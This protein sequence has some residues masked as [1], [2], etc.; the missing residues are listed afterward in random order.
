MLDRPDRPT[1]IFAA[2]DPQALGVYQ[3]ARELGLR[4]PADLSVVGFDDLPVVSWADPPMTTVHQPLAEMAA[5]ATELALSLG[6]GEPAPQLGL[7]IGT[8][9]TVR[10]STAF[11]PRGRSASDLEIPWEPIDQPQSLWLTSHGETI[12]IAC[13]KFPVVQTRGSDMTDAISRRRF[14]S[15][16]ALIAGAVAGSPLLAACGDGPKGSTGPGTTDKD[17]LS[18]VLPAYTPNKSVTADIPP[19]AGANGA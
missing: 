7:E 9:L 2:T 15:G 13:G 11:P 4:I 17:A 8:T 6:R 12:E 19:V 5:A 3:A 1:A 18:K 16:A 14:V 10:S